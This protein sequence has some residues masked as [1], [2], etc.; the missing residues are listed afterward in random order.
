[1]NPS[2]EHMHEL[3]C[4]FARQTAN[5]VM[6]QCR[7]LT[8]T[9]IEEQTETYDFW[10]LLISAH[11]LRRA[12]AL[13]ENYAKDS[14]PIALGTMEL[15]KCVPDLAIARN[16][17]MH[18]DEY[19]AGKG[20][21]RND[22]AAAGI[23]PSSLSLF[24]FRRSSRTIIWSPMKATFAGSDGGFRVVLEELEACIRTLLRAIGDS[25]ARDDS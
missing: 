18:F 1:M 22:A 5:M 19:L 21:Q 4:W 10:F 20:R 24:E 17:F 13:I 16:I 8:G 23:N 14:K 11:Q 9:S 6:L 2:N 12:M 3:A 7:R 25:E 15:D